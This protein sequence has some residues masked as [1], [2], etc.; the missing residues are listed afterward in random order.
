MTERTVTPH[1]GG[2][3][4]SFPGT[5]ISQEN[6]DRLAEIVESR[7]ATR[8]GKRFTVA[9]WIEEKILEECAHKS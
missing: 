9:D 6:L 8:E 3:T 7:N 4:K 5:R 2:R 1:K